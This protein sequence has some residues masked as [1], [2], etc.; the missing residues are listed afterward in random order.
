LLRTF[1]GS[2]SLT[3]NLYGTP[4]H[5][6]VV[7]TTAPLVTTGVIPVKKTFDPTLK[8]GEKVIDD[9]GAPPMSTSVTRDVY[10]ADGKLL[11][12]DTWYSSYRASPKLV[13]LPEPV[14]K[15]QQQTTTTQQQ[16]PPH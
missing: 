13:R 3:V 9:P 1:V 8:P 12:H 15:K 2:Y 7:S 16:T 11:Y 6:R 14:Q 4:V 5:R 10:D